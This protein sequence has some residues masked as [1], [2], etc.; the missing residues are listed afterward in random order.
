MTPATFHHHGAD[1]RAT[2]FSPTPPYISSSSAQTPDSWTTSPTHLASLPHPDHSYATSV[3]LSSPSNT[4]R[5]NGLAPVAL[6]VGGLGA[7]ASGSGSGDRVTFRS[8]REPHD[9]LLSSLDDKVSLASE[10]VAQLHQ[11]LTAASAALS[12]YLTHST[13]LSSA[14][15]ALSPSASLQ[16]YVS[17]HH[18]LLHALTAA[19]S[20]YSIDVL[21]PLTDWLDDAS[22]LAIELGHTQLTRHQLSASTDE[23]DN[24]FML[25]AEEAV[26]PSVDELITD[27]KSKVEKLSN[28]YS[29]QLEGVERS[30][31]KVLEGRERM[32]EM[33]GRNWR[34]WEWK[35]MKRWSKL[36][37]VLGK[38]EGDAD[39]EEKDEDEEEED[40]KEEADGQHEAD[41]VEDAAG[42][43]DYNR[44]LSPELSTHTRSVA[45]KGDSRDDQADEEWQTELHSNHSDSGSDD[46]D[47]N[48]TLWNDMTSP[49]SVSFSAS[50]A[51]T[52]PPFSPT[53][54]SSMPQPPPN[55]PYKPPAH[56]SVP[57]TPLPWR[58]LP[59][60]QLTQ[61]VWL[62]L[63]GSAYRWDEERDELAC[64]YEV[65]AGEGK[66]EVEKVFRRR[67]RG[68]RKDGDGADEAAETEAE[69]RR[70]PA[71]VVRL[72]SESREDEVEA[73]MRRVGLSA[74]EVMAALLAVDLDKLTA[75]KVNRLISILPTD[76][77]LAKLLESLSSSA[78]SSSSLLSSLSP[79]S[80][81]LTSLIAPMQPSLISRLHCLHYY[82]QLP[83][84][85]SC[86]LSSLLLLHQTATQLRESTLFHHTLAA[87][88]ELFN[89][90]HPAQVS[91]AF[92]IRLLSSLSN[93]TARPSSPP[94]L[95]FLVSH[96]ASHHPQLLS[97]PA[98]LPSLHRTVQLSAVSLQSQLSQLSSNVS[99]FRSMLDA[100]DESAESEDVTARQRWLRLFDQLLDT[101]DKVDKRKST[102]AA[103]CDE[104]CSFLCYTQPPPDQQPPYPL[105]TAA[106]VWALLQLLDSFVL[107]FSTARQKEERQAY[108]T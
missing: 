81:L 54:A 102:T 36:G 73:V 10:P 35:A 104:L 34:E 14:L 80:L 16:Q 97:F 69:H 87:I 24:L 15:Q 7:G 26:P 60:T 94:F 40:E 77:E 43:D 57:L 17:Y 96:L 51:I 29:G 20:F 83:T 5:H 25:K 9:P 8:V 84:L 92:D 78:A 89:Y 74:Q 37:E 68:E 46:D 66:E 44:L 63:F 19:S 28:V 18:S 11:H 12:S 56:P 71:Q 85:S 33:V 52:S 93:L 86:I 108:S 2:V 4:A 22:Q 72:L 27:R 53:A 106:D 62:S 91:Y 47:P 49:K 101:Q 64:V 79:A 95:A 48:D 23:L 76:A 88:L 39:M 55:F 98:S 1:L 30:V 100:L 50:S 59:P 32:V 105:P 58:P 99:A 42:D 75:D 70:Q 45:R 103:K 31:R 6:A 13:A 38:A 65:R 90:L 41:D 21:Y 3:T 107:E 67:R 82:Y 61:S